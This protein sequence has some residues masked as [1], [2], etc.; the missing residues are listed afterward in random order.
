MP[1]TE[2]MTAKKTRML[3]SE[4]FNQSILFKTARKIWVIRI[5]DN[6]KINVPA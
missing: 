4:N 5:P 1:D 2:A 6:T 3:T